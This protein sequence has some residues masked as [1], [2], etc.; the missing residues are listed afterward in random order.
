MNTI[1]VIK[2]M[3]HPIPERLLVAKRRKKK[4]TA[5]PPS[6]V[7]QETSEG[8][9]GNKRF[10][11]PK[12]KLLHLASLAEKVNDNHQPIE[13]NRPTIVYSGIKQGMAATYNAPLKED[14]KTTWS[15][16]R[17]VDTRKY[18]G[19]RSRKRPD[20]YKDKSRGIRKAL[21]TVNPQDL[22]AEIDAYIE[23]C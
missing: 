9:I 18:Y 7:K 21:R 12:G 23:Q 17:R 10:R 16:D 13:D 8:V 5:T 11:I 20:Y 1:R 4:K 19:I 6:L 2:E 3:L 14:G 15:F 22:M